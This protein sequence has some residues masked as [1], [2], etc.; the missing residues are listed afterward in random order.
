MNS[1]M[2]PLL[3]SLVV[4]LALLSDSG[5]AG[6]WTQWRGP[7]REDRS[8]DKGLLKSWPQGGP[9]QLWVYQDAGL[10]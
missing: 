8:P 3:S 10:G 2:K 6:E 4:S 5:V 1:R 7:G 9:K